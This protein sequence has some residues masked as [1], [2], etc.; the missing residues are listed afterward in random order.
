MPPYWTTALLLLY[1]V[2]STQTASVSSLQT[3]QPSCRCLAHDGTGARLAYLI[4]LH[5]AHTLRNAA[6][7]FPTLVAVNNIV[8]IHVD[9]KLSWEE[10]ENSVLKDLVEHCSCGAIIQVVSFYDCQWGQ[11]SMNDPL[12]WS[13]ELLTFDRRFQHQWDIYINLSADSLPV[14]TP[15]TLSRLFDPLDGPLRH[16]NFVTSSISPTG[17]L[18]TELSLFPEHWHKR[19]HYDGDYTLDYFEHPRNHTKTLRIHFG[20][21]WTMLEPRFV[22]YVASSLRRKDSLPSMFRELLISQKKWMTDEVFLPTLLI[23]N[24]W[25]RDTLPQMDDNGALIGRPELFDVR[26]ER[27][28]EHQPTVFGEVTF[29]PKYDVPLS[30]SIEVPKVWGPYYLGMYDLSKVKYSGA[31]FVRKVTKEVDPN[32]FRLLPVDH[33]DQIPDIRW[34]EEVRISQRERSGQ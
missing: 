28:D 33:V 30:A 34:P 29:D 6:S 10:Y 15:Q 12:H 1:S 16:T 31:L 32:L 8:L 13:I 3:T 26:Y 23:N 14:Y 21:Q 7:L 25:F 9:R 17:M 19:I 5:N 18:P 20:S 11:W 27:M 22:Q 2:L 24:R 4:S